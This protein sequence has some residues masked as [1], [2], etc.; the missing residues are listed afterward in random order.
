MIE[1]SRL[2]ALS[3]GGSKASTATAYSYEANAFMGFINHSPMGDKLVRSRFL[4]CFLKR[5]RMDKSGEPTKDYYQ[6]LAAAL[7]RDEFRGK[8]SGHKFQRSK[9]VKHFHRFLAWAKGYYS[10]GTCFHI[11]LLCRSSLQTKY[12][13]INKQYSTWQCRSFHRPQM[14]SHIGR[15]VKVLLARLKF[16]DRLISVS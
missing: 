8:F 3:T 7:G 6:L 1:R 11:F 16:Y 4:L 14:T 13:R 5:G 12:S 9:S 15:A 10:P 2:P